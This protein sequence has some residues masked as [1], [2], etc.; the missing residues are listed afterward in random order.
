MKI[1]DTCGWKLK[2]QHNPKLRLRCTICLFERSGGRGIGHG[3]LD[4]LRK[5][6][7]IKINDMQ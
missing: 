7:W 2:K 3:C 5:E 1:C 6:Y 4:A